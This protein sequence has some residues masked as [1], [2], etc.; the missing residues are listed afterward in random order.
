MGPPIG[1]PEEMMRPP[2]LLP[3]PC[4]P[5]NL[6]NQIFNLM[7]NS[8]PLSCDSHST[9]LEVTMLVHHKPNTTSTRDEA[10]SAGVITWACVHDRRVCDYDTVN[11]MVVVIILWRVWALWGHGPTW[12]CGCRGRFVAGGHVLAGGPP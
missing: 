6:Y 5:H 10:G 2:I 1:P 4:T 11:I 9:L 12:V 7:T 3:S 8:E